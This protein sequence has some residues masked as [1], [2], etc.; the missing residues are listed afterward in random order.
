M[1]AMPPARQERDF[2]TLRA[3]IAQFPDGASLDQIKE[4]AGLPVSER[5]LIRRLGQM[6]EKALIRKSGESR[7]ARYFIEGA[8]PAKPI[9]V[10]AAAQTD[11]FVPVSKAGGEILRLV[12]QPVQARKPVGYNRKFLSDYRP[13]VTSYLTAADKARLATISRT[14][15]DANPRAGTY[16]QRILARLLIDL[17]WNSSR[18]EGNTYSLIDTQRLIEAGR[19]SNSWCSR[20]RTSPSTATPS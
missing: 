13:N 4:A 16:A 18:L 3:A 14:I 7:A 20:P 11:M 8:A 15:D 10:A 5:T 6:A 19:P 1:A 17:S 12:S 2:A 9:E